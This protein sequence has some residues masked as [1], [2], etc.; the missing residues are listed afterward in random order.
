MTPRKP[1]VDTAV[2]ETLRGQGERLAFLAFIAGLL[3]IAFLAGFLV[4]E[5]RLFPSAHLVRLEEA[6]RALWRAYFRETYYV[7][8]APEGVDGTVPQVRMYDR[9]RMSP[10]LTLVVGYRGNRF[11]AWLVDEEGREI[12]RWK[13]AFSEA[14]PTAPHLRWQAPD[15]RIAWQG[16]QLLPQGDLLFNFQDTNFPYGSGLV[17]IDRDSNVVWR[18]AENTHHDLAF[19]DEGHLWAP[20]MSVVDDATAGNRHPWHYEDEI[21][22]IAPEDGRVLRRLTVSRSAASFPGLLNI[23]YDS[24]LILDAEDP[25]HLNAVEPLPARIADR[26]PLFAPGDLLISMRN[27]NTIA[28]L[29]RRSGLVKWAL[30]GLFVRQHDPDWMPNGHILLFD[31]RGGAPPCSGSRILEIDPVSQQIVWQYD[32]APDRCFYSETRGTVELLPNSNV[33]VA[34]SHSGR[35][36]EV[37]RETPPRLVWEYFN[38]LPE[39]KD[40]KAQV[41]I[42]LHAARYARAELP[43]LSRP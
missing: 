11:E 6:A 15:S 32:G 28:V 20:G 21:L 8:P 23:T 3:L 26:F 18:L 14:F 10:G 34:D 9:A 40:G 1:S 36:F 37:T 43:F 30:T 4:T 7:R 35:V 38:L 31:N 25:L 12:H 16:V 41:G 19:D 13:L 22:E 27:S 17:R 5:R 33:L 42:V 24:S 39:R 29:D 2:R